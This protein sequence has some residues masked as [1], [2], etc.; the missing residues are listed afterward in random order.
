MER[1]GK[2]AGSDDWQRLHALWRGLW[3][4]GWDGSIERNRTVD[5]FE[6][7]RRDTIRR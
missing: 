3:Q 1:P 6:T 2:Y 7:E 4:K 5:L